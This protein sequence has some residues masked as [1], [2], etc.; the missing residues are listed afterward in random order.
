MDAALRRAWTTIVIPD[1]YE[2]HMASIGQAQAAARL[3]TQIIAWAQLAPGSRITVA[4]AGTGQMLDHLDAA[5]VQPFRLVFS[6][7]NSTFLA[8]LSVRLK[9]HR[10]EAEVVKDDIEQTRLKPEPDLL[11]ATLLLE[12]I[13][14]KRG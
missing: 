5:G 13:E 14:W 7:L 9:T 1:D 3:T 10:L 6:D 8:R 11:I 12:H 4:G 2:Q